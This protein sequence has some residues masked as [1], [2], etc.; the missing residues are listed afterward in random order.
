MEVLQRVVFMEHNFCSTYLK[1]LIKVWLSNGRCIQFDIFL[2][3]EWSTA[4][5][6]AIAKKSI[7]LTCVF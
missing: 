6:N 7:V 2:K 4:G 5:T 1:K 3:G